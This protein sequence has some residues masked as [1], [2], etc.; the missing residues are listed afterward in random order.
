MRVDRRH[1]VLVLGQELP[2]NDGAEAAILDTLESV[3]DRSST[4][5][6]LAS[7]IVDWPT[8]YHFSRLRRNLF[9]PFRLESGMRILEIGCGTGANLVAFAES[10]AEVVGV[11]GSIGRARA[12]RIRTAGHDNVT[13]YAGDVS[14]L[15]SM[16]PFDVVAL[17][18]VL[19]YSPS[20]IGGAGGPAAMLDR[21][22]A[23]TKPD[24]AL[25]LAIENQLGLKYLLSHPEDH[26][27][28]P[29]IGLEDYP[30]KD[31]ARTW[32]R[33]ELHTMLTTAGFVDQEWLYP[34]PDYK[35]PIFVTGDE[36]FASDAGREVLKQFLRDPVAE[37]AGTASLVCDAKR[38]FDLMV[39]AGLG[40]D[41]ANSFLVVG[42]PTA[43]GAGQLIG[44]GSAWLSSGERL[45]RFRSQRVIVRDDQDWK[46]VPTS[47]PSVA[48]PGGSAWVRNVG[49]E[50][51]PIV[52]GEC[53]EDQAI[54]ALRDDDMSALAAILQIFDDF[55]AA[56][57]TADES[58][59]SHPYLVSSDRPRLSG[60]LLDG[61]LKNLIVDGEGGIHF[62]DREW[63]LDGGV[64]EELIR[65]RAYFELA[66]RIRRAGIRHRWSSAGTI[67]DLVQSLGG[68]L[69]RGWSEA[70]VERFARAE[71]EL[72]RIV[73]GGLSGSVEAALRSRPEDEAAAL[74]TLSLIRQLQGIESERE[75]YRDLLTTH[76]HVLA[77][78][79]ELEQA[80]AGLATVHRELER[81]HED[82][83][84][85][86]REL[87]QAHRQLIGSHAEA[88][89]LVSS[90]R[91]EVEAAREEQ[92]RLAEEVRT[93]R[94]SRSYRIGRVLTAPLR[95]FR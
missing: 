39:D 76:E 77:T 15:P 83:A 5:D 12:A 6:E 17:I 45:Q 81:A 86:H 70:D 69:G 51:Q 95:V 65:I 20:V 30:D 8:R 1:D 46:V 31:R 87:E 44:D 90:T 68:V 47:G 67:G 84:A 52:L 55:L 4:S 24:G 57:R 27:G 49:H 74:S 38:A 48:S 78:H 11:E 25:I 21:A 9:E 50:S 19:E 40:P 26:L 61:T 62:V 59:A 13:V 66:S 3:G 32:T 10:G 7:R 53:L 64:D 88:Q 2:Y 92:G 33:R 82:L 23:L 14:D 71:S 22:R 42:S 91:A 56:N 85:V 89:S 28:L 75:G 60:D 36:L 79:R 58:A 94:S 37:H 18:G 72:Q 73:S 54:D 34:F 16:E 63:T 43:G 35:L 29:W 93:L 80:H 41:T